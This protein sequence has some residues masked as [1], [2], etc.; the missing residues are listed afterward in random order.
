MP[1]YYIVPVSI[2]N[3]CDGE[4][5]APINF[6]GLLFDFI[7]KLQYVDL[8]QENHHTVI[9]A[10]DFNFDITTHPDPFL[11]QHTRSFVIPHYDVKPLREGKNKI[12]FFVISKQ[13]ESKVKEVQAHDLQIPMVVKQSIGEEIKDQRT[14]TNHNPLSATIE[15]KE[16]NWQLSELAHL[17]GHC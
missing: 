9:I 11:W 12:D 1:N 2:C 13:L 14:I 8:L 5:E 4:I 10:G 7:S 6:A 3:Y 16:I 15:V 17:L